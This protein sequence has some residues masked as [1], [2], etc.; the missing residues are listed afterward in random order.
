MKALWNYLKEPFLVQKVQQFFGVETK[1][2]SDTEYRINNKFWFF[3]FSV[4]SEV[5]D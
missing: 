2:K 4:F 5:C 1:E 3:L